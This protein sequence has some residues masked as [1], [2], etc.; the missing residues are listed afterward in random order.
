MELAGNE[1]KIQALFRE[2]KLAD[3]RVAPGFTR[4]W[5]RAQATNPGSPRVFKI[6]FAV[7]TAL[8]V[9]TLCSLVIWSRNWQRSQQSNPGVATGPTTPDSTPAPLLAPPLVKPL[10]RPLANQGPTQLGVAQPPNRVKSNRWDR[11]LVA[12]RQADLNAGNAPIR[13][14]ISISSWQSPTATLMQSPADNVLTS[15]PLL[16]RSLTELKTFLP[17]TP[18]Y[19]NR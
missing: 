16:D 12:R 13:E 7:A 8:F 3:E 10:A 15:L 19:Q 5:D 18:S 9:I 17:N 4:V 11:K 14:T 2:L 1:K 6:S